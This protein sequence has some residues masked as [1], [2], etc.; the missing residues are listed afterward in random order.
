MIFAC[1][2]LLEKCIMKNKLFY[3]VVF[4]LLLT[5]GC[6][7]KETLG[8]PPEYI[9]GEWKLY[10]ITAMGTD[11]SVTDC[12]K[13][14]MMQF[15]SNHDA[16]AVYYTIYQSTGDCH[17]HLEYSG[18]WEYDED[19]DTFYFDVEDTAGVQEQEAK[20]LHFLDPDHFYV[21]EEYQHIPIT[22]YFEKV[23]NN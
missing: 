9:V 23:A 13:R 12:H 17:K 8:S 19:D 10:R 11:Q 18:K 5:A 22:V 15:S 20:Q 16:Y 3:L 2:F 21:E 4:F 1:V 14:S 6:K 7:K